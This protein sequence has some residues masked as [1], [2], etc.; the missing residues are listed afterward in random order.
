[1]RKF[2]GYR[3]GERIRGYD[4][5]CVFDVYLE[6]EI[7][8]VHRWGEPGVDFDCYEVKVERRVV[9][10]EDCPEFCGEHFY[11]PMELD[12]LDFD[13][14]VMPAGHDNLAREIAARNNACG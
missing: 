10:G 1:M 12:I 9:N 5:I 13:W 14:R 7:V 11:I 6:G 3:V 4:F 2:D 8:A